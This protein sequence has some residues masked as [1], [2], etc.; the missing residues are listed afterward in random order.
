LNGTTTTIDLSQ[1]AYIGS[2]AFSSDG[3]WLA[4]DGYSGGYQGAAP[5]CWIVKADG[6]QPRKVAV[7]QTPRWSPDGTK[8][9]LMR[10]REQDRALGL[11]IFVV[12]ADG[13]EEHRISDGRWPDWSPDGNR[14]VFAVGGQSDRGG[15]WPGSRV[16]VCN[17]DGGD[18]EEIGSGDCP[19]WSPDGTK[20]ACCVVDPQVAAPMLR[21]IDLESRGESIVAYGWY[22]ANWSSDG[23]GLYANSVSQSGQVGMFKLGAE[24]GQT[25]QPIFADIRGAESP[26]ASRDGKWIVFAA[27]NTGP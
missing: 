18:V 17:L 4:F 24:K 20:V 23:T 25:S 13:T 5:E 27:P 6:T 19:S 10:C 9:V 16:C 11:G 21:I 2:P 8:L 15:A 14:L 12:N 1:F 3:Q 26:C 7:G 22:R